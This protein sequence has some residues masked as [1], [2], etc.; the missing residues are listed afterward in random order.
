MNLPIFTEPID[1]KPVNP[2][3]LEI[4]TRL[5]ALHSFAGMTDDFDEL[6]DL[7]PILM[8]LESDLA[9]LIGLIE[10]K[11]KDMRENRWKATQTSAVDR[12]VKSWADQQMAEWQRKAVQS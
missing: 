5:I 11:T 1:R 8:G 2:H 6:A 10:N 4:A 12:R 9:H 7:F 3:A